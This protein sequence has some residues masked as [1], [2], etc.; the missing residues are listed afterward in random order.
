[1]ALLV[2]VETQEGEWRTFVIAH[3]IAHNYVGDVDV[4]GATVP[5]GYRR[6]RSWD[7]VPRDEAERMAR[8]L[9][10]A[11][12]SKRLDAALKAAAGLRL[13]SS[14]GPWA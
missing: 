12:K 11:P 14:A 10:G 6:L 9:R 3:Q 2:V 5:G 1:M 8:S 13:R 4:L 7:G